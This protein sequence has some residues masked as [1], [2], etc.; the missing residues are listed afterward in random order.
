MSKI[1]TK[2]KV[3]REAGDHGLCGMLGEAAVYH[4][5][6][7]VKDAEGN[8]TQYVW[9]STSTVR[10]KVETYIFPCDEKGDTFSMIEMQGSEQGV[11]SHRRVLSGL[12]FELSV[13]LRWEG[14]PGT[15]IYF[16]FRD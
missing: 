16:S 9:V 6:E 8:E 4:L 3:T 13:Q 7:P 14:A 2:V 10:G 12:G 1:A 5:S 15:G 11:S